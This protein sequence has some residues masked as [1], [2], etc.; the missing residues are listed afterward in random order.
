[1]ITNRMITSKQF[2]SIIQ[3]KLINNH[4]HHQIYNSNN[5]K[6]RKNRIKE[7]WTL[8]NKNNKKNYKGKQN[9]KYI[10]KWRNF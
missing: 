1:M 5:N 10:E 8:F 2:L 9:K 7:N 6:A 4:H 3:I